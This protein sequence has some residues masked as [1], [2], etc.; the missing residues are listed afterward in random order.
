MTKP[1]LLPLP[2]SIAPIGPMNIAD[3]EARS[4][5]PLRRE[6]MSCDGYVLRPTREQPTKLQAALLKWV[7]SHCRLLT[8]SRI[9]PHLPRGARRVGFLA[10]DNTPQPFTRHTGHRAVPRAFED[11]IGRHA[12]LAA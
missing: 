4:S 6:T 9:F 8:G 7:P 3:W 11:S 12:S 5:H 10:R 2:S 1:H